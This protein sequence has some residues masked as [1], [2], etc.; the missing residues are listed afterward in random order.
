MRE[1]ISA[2]SVRA[3]PVPFLLAV[4][5]GV[6]SA[7]G[8]GGKAP[9]VAADSGM[10]GAPSQDGTATV[11]SDGGT[12]VSEGESGTQTADVGTSP[13]QIDGGGASAVGQ[14]AWGVP[15]DGGPWSAVCPLSNP[16]EGAACSQEVLQCEYGNAWWNFSCDQVLECLNGVWTNEAYG[17]TTCEPQPG[18]NPPSCP[19]DTGSFTSNTSCPLAQIKVMCFYGQGSSCTCLAPP[20]LQD[21]GAPNSGPL[22]ECSPEPGCPSTRP[23]LGEPCKTGNLCTY[24]GITEFCQNHVWQIS[25]GGP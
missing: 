2:Y 4:T 22:W 14:G 25:V 16:G 21:G 15:L 18:P 17:R 9:S 6:A 20:S 7:Y 24:G 3:L 19:P 8:C 11:A 13:S 12:S 1:G 23:R 5:S 10:Q